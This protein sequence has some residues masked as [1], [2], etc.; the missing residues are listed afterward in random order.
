MKFRIKNRNRVALSS[1]DVKPVKTFK[2]KTK[3]RF[4]GN[5]F[6]TKFNHPGKLYYFCSWDCR[7]KGKGRIHRKQIKRAQLREEK[8]KEIARI[9]NMRRSTEYN[10]KN[11]FEIYEQV[12]ERN[13][14]LKKMVFGHYSKGIFK[15]VWCGYTDVRA[16]TIDHM[17]GDGAKHR[18]EI[19]GGDI[20]RWI[21]KNN[22]PDGFQIMCMNCQFIKREADYRK[23]MA[24][25][26]GSDCF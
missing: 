18:R 21:I 1:N 6:M 24:E 5:E 15:C 11:H 10:H 13:Q 12:R 14:E 25:K 23:K 26:Y 19:K 2:P 7:L 4:C 16:L 20:K 8:K 3:C 22:F 9:K 17:N